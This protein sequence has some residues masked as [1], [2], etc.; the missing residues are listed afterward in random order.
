M[1]PQITNLFKGD[2]KIFFLGK[3]QQATLD[4]IKHRFI[5]APILWHFYPHLAMVVETDA[6]D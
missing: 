5:S 1:C 2:R 6:W 4:D 3:D